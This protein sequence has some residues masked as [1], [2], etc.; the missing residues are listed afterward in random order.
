VDADLKD[1]IAA[2]LGDDVTPERRAQLI[3]RL[4]TDPAFRRAFVEEIRMLGKLKA[5]QS[6][7]P[8]WLK[9]EDEMGVEKSNRQSE[10]ML[11]QNVIG[12]VRS[13]SERLVPGWWRLLALGSACA[14]IVLMAGW[15]VVSE[16]EAV[17]TGPRGIMAENSRQLAVAVKA[18][19]TRWDSRQG[20]PITEGRI[21]ESGKIRLLAG[22]L[23]LAYFSGVVLNIEGPADVDLVSIDKV[24]CRFGKLRTQVPP[25]AE[26]FTVTAPGSSVVDLGTEVGL[27]VERDGRAKL[28]VFEGKAQVSVLSSK[29][30]T[31]QSRVLEGQ[32]AVDIDPGAGRILQSNASSAS[33]ASKPNIV[34][35]SLVL[36]REYPKVV[37]MS[38]PWG[39]WRF[40]SMDGGMVPNEIEGKP[41]LHVRG[42]LQLSDI[43]SGN[44]SI[45]FREGAKEQSLLMDELWTPPVQGGYAL[46]FWLV[47]EAFTQCSLVSLITEQTLYYSLVEL[48]AS[49]RRLIHDPVSVRF[50]HRWPPGVGGGVNVYSRSIYFP[51]RWCHIVAQRNGDCMELF[52]DGISAARTPLGEAGG[53][54]PC[55]LLLGYLLKTS[56]PLISRSFVGRIDELAVYEHP[57][58]AE[59]IKRHARLGGGNQQLSLAGGGK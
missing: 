22:R 30:V 3:M 42:P 50:L 59:E 17:L 36:A 34:V 5:V 53:P 21:V 56:D 27:N 45:I 9:L 28:M 4:R 23:M 7:E 2:W 48:T 38:R 54:T 26:G 35:P 37:S 47:S 6:N 44:R 24:F 25:G 14:L 49:S 51:Y 39:Y 33:F 32:S 41:C 58:S 8:R 43:V 40:E 13:L 15:W 10:A 46:E 52:V 16:R 31:L 18:E 19:D 20:M 1:L 55:R 12:S 57:L 11:E 29:G